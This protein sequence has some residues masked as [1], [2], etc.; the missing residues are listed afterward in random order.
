MKH[1]LVGPYPPPH[2][3][4]SV[5]LSG[6]H[7]QLTMS[8]APCAVLDP[9]RCAGTLRFVRTLLG[10]ASEGWT[11]HLHTNGHNAKSW[12]LALLCSFA[13]KIN[14]GDGILTLHS[15]MVPG[16]LLATWWHRKLAQ[17]VCPLYHRIIC[18]SPA[19]GAAI[20]SL[21]I[22]PGRVQITPAYLAANLTVVPLDSRLLAW[23]GRHQPLLSTALFFRPEYGF[24]LLV[25]S[26]D[27]LRTRY[28]SVGCLVMGSGEQHQEAVKRI[29]DAHLED[30]ILL[31]GDVEHDRCL[32]LMARCDVFLRPTLEDGDSISVREALSLGV[33]VVASRVGTRPDGVILFRPGDL[34]DMLSNIELALTLRGNENGAGNEPYAQSDGGVVVSRSAYVTT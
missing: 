10:Y 2:G 6:L 29:R 31:L 27:R 15:G 28:P 20:V 33:P 23:I 1:L 30:S 4:I 12:L 3:G 26:L 25:D 17:L 8:G 34:E 24:D 32:A 21:G 19:I 18:V 16:Y 11:I 22:D 5:H 14:G 7:R 9:H 13:E